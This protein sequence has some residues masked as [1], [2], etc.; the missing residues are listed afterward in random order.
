MWDENIK[1]PFD[2]CVT[3]QKEWVATGS[4]NNTAAT[5]LSQHECTCVGVCKHKLDLLIIW[6]NCADSLG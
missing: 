6:I 4:I 2:R 5:I 3:S 1:T